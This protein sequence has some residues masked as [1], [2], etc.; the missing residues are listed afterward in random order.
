MGLFKNNGTELKRF[1]LG[2]LVYDEYYGAGVVIDLDRKFNEM[3]VKFRKP[4]NNIWLTTFSVKSLEIISKAE[5]RELLTTPLQD[6]P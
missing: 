6:K 3:E 1:T 4:E 5:D 2:D